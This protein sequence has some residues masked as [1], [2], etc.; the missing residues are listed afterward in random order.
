MTRDTNNKTGGSLIAD[1]NAF[2]L[3]AEILKDA[4]EALAELPASERTWE[5]QWV[6][7]I[8]RVVAAH[9]YTGDDGALAAV[10]VQWRYS[11]LA[12]L[13]KEGGGAGFRLAANGNDLVIDDVLLL[14]AAQ[15]PLIDGPGPIRFDSET[16]HRRVLELADLK[17]SA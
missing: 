10:A 15:V 11:A 13:M 1:V 12:A 4:A 14:C 3:P 2:A 6:P 7:T 5:G 8:V 16:Y 17:G 9:G